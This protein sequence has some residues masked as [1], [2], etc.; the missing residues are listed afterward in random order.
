MLESICRCSGWIKGL[1][2]HGELCFLNDDV[3]NS[4]YEKHKLGGLI[5]RPNLKQE[6][7]DLEMLCGGKVRSVKYL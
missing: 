2:R 3:S 6:E 5:T 4:I 7:K 1:A